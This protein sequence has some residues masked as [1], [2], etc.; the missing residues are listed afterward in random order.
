MHGQEY[1]NIRMNCQ[2]P[3]REPV[4]RAIRAPAS[5]DP[6]EA[7]DAREPHGGDEPDATC[8]ELYLYDT[9]IVMGGRPRVVG[10]AKRASGRAVA[11]GTQPGKPSHGFRPRAGAVRLPVLSSVDPEAMRLRAAVRALVR[12][13]SIS[14][15]ADTACCGLTVAQAATLEALAGEPLRLGAVGQRLGIAPSTLTRN[16]ARLEEAGLVER[17]NDPSDAR[18]ARVALTEAGREA[19]RGVERQEQA[20]ARDVLGRLPADRRV[21]ALQALESL[22]GAVREATEACCPGAFDHLLKDAGGDET[23]AAGEWAARRD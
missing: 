4:P 14:E 16:L 11:G 15:R 6:L 7:A 22:L 9:S 18:A 3:G 10:R 13:F 17:E 8:K 19:A 1:T 5:E 12:R 23:Q 21:A 20:F 2:A